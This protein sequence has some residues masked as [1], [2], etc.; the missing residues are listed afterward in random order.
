MIY[1]VKSSANFRENKFIIKLNQAEIV[2]EMY[3]DFKFSLTLSKIRIK[4]N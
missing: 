3:V 2:A 1:V 4:N